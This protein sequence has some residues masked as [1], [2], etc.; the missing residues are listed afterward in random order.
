MVSLTH[1]MWLS[2]CVCVCARAHVWDRG[3]V[4]TRWSY[5]SMSVPKRSDCCRMRAMRSGPEMPSGNAGKF[6]TSVVVVS[7]PPAGRT[8][9]RVLG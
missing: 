4:G 8:P 5:V 9:S 3:R 1:T 2:L 6:S 7:W